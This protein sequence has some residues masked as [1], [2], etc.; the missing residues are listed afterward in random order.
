ML[1]VL[2]S[3]IYFVFL[4]PAVKSGPRREVITF[5]ALRQYDGY[6]RR[7]DVVSTIEQVKHSTGH[8]DVFMNGR[9]LHVRQ[10]ELT[11]IGTVLTFRSGRHYNH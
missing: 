11:T 9:I 6:T 10:Y 7:Q 5:A 4:L 1:A 8:M 3:W 2:V